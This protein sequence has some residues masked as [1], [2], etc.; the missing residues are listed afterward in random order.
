MAKPAKMHP[1]FLN[2]HLKWLIYLFFI[3]K[4]YISS[5][6]H[7]KLLIITIGNSISV[8]DRLHTDIASIK[9]FIEFLNSLK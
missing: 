1:V 5:H 2:I 4:S 3:F 6:L 8:P 7:L 9:E